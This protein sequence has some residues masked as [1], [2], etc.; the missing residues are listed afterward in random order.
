MKAKLLPLQGKYY[1]TEV[2]IN[3]EGEEYLIELW[4][5]TTPPSIRELDVI[6]PQEWED[7][8]DVSLHRKDVINWYGC[9]TIPAQDYFE[10]CDSHFESDTTYRLAQKLVKLINEG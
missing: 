2:V 9:N 5:G 6:T 1:G 3:F 8:V 10:I 4:G 7:N